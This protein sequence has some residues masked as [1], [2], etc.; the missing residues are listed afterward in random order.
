MLDEIR[1][2]FD[3]LAREHDLII[4]FYCPD[5]TQLEITLYN[6][7]RWW[8]YKRIVVID[9]I[10]RFADTPSQYVDMIIEHTERKISKYELRNQRS[11][12]QADLFRMS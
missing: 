9:E 2:R 6:R 3:R 8:A 7:D 1:L 5:D 11:N 4:E 10:A 12:L